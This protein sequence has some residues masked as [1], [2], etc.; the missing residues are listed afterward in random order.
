MP[1]PSRA[2]HGGKG[3]FLFDVDSSLSLTKPKAALG[4]GW[5]TYRN[6][7]RPLMSVA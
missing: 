5:R 3:M 6:A 7:A 2:R 4:S 1:K